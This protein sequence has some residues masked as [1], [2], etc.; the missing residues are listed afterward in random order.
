MSGR[1]IGTLVGAAIGTFFGQP[2]LGA[3]IG[4]T[5]GGLLM[6]DEV[7]IQDQEGPRLTEAKLTSTMYG[8]SIERIFGSYRIGG[9]TIW[10]KPIR[11]TK[12]VTE[13]EVGKGGSE[14]YDVITY[15]YDVSFAVAFCEGPIDSISKIW[16][17]SVK[18]YDVDLGGYTQS[19]LSSEESQG[20]IQL[21][22]GTSD[23]APDWVIQASQPDTPAY[24][25]IAY[26][27]FN[28]FQLEK[29]GERMPNITCEVNKG[30]N[31]LKVLSY[32]APL[33]EDDSAISSGITSDT[34]HYFTHN[35]DT[36]SITCYER[37]GLLG[38]HSEKFSSDLGSSYTSR[39]DT[40]KS[41]INCICTLAHYPLPFTYTITDR[42]NYNISFRADFQRYDVNTQI[43]DQTF[44]YKGKVLIYNRYYSNDFDHNR[45]IEVGTDNNISYKVVLELGQVSGHSVSV[46]ND[47]IYVI[48]EDFKIRLYSYDNYSYIGEL[49]IP[50]DFVYGS[51]APHVNATTVYP[52]DGYYYISISTNVMQ[53][54]SNTGITL[55]TFSSL[56][57]NLNLGGCIIINDVLEK[58]DSYYSLGGNFGARY[59]NWN[60]K[61]GA[62]VT[63]KSI[64]EELSIA[65]NIDA[66]ELDLDE[67]NSKIITGFSVPNVSE[68]RSA[69]SVLQSIY[70]FDLFEEDFKLKIKLRGSNPSKTVSSF[71]LD[72]EKD[73]FEASR[74]LDTELPKKITLKYINSERDYLSGSQIAL[75]IEGNSDNNAIIE[76]P[77]SLTD[78][79]AK[80]LVEKL[81]F[82]S[83]SGNM[84]M[85]FSIPMDTQLSLCDVITVQYD[86]ISYIVRI[87]K[88]V[89]NSDY[90]YD[91]EATTE[92]ANSY[93]SNAIGSDTSEG[94][95]SSISDKA[96]YTVF[97]V[98]N[99][100]TLDN[101]IINSLGVYIAGTGQ[102]VDLWKGCGVFKSKD[103][104]LTYSSQGAIIN[105]IQIGIAT[106]ILPTGPTTVWD[107]D[108][109]VNIMLS[110][111]DT[112]PSVSDSVLMSTPKE[113]FVLIG[114][115]VLQYGL[116]TLE[117]DGSFT[118][119]RLIRGRRGTEWA[120][121]QHIA[122]EDFVVLKYDV[123]F[124]PS[125]LNIERYY[126]AVTFGY[127][128]EDSISKVQTCDGT[129]LKPFAPSYIQIVLETNGDRTISWTRRDRY[130]SGGF[131]TLPNSELQEKYKIEF[132]DG[133]TIKRT[134]E[135]ID[136]TTFV[137]LSTDYIADLPIDRIKV[138]QYSDNLLAY[139][140]ATEELI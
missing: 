40:F 31:E 39:L 63:L 122:D 24:R 111:D 78:T 88:I 87:T 116:A 67:G 105:P 54:I 83:W 46:H 136:A 103:E 82:S 60:L 100:P 140:Y 22:L 134:E 112:L 108:N 102:V 76:A 95:T 98:F 62:S 99:A 93:V 92:N 65:S 79:E 70:L 121:D 10:A 64:V 21:Y 126:K 35:Y 123:V 61:S 110:S 131:N 56:N 127:S 96:G 48:C 135:V 13:E 37:L 74:I 118:L 73:K 71:I 49:S 115:E 3:S 12:H 129:S 16:A 90:I 77:I 26:I 6:P 51:S 137:Y 33:A 80:Q 58:I 8:K 66:I 50:L 18:I 2:Q 30:A 38:A 133:V 29:F 28:N 41:D 69:I 106:D 125:T 27:R 72:M 52:H 11:E 91:C 113:N 75:R 53:K 128:L 5:V 89:I 42:N 43:S 17:D 57:I 85:A 15:S 47:M 94:F 59:F 44:Y 34:N 55:Q 101:T 20:T 45:L 130:L 119:S 1:Q 109:T 68:A 84:R 138:S 32:N 86:N 107:L 139:G 132:L 104:G 81:L 9:N 25:N 124:S 120:V 97:N 19:F 7:G 23:Q 4:G 117:L 36:D 14:T 114:Q